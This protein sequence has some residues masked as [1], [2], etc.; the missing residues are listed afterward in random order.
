[1]PVRV[2]IDRSLCDSQALCATIAPAVFAMDDDDTNQVLVEFPEGD[3]LA[4]AQLAANACP[5]GAIILTEE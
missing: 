2:S 5:K 1:M 3:L 4:R